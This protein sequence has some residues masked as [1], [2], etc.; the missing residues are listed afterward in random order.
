MQGDE[1]RTSESTQR[2][3]RTSRIRTQ[4]PANEG[5]EQ[6]KNR[7]DTRSGRAYGATHSPYHSSFE[8]GTSACWRRP[9]RHEGL[10]TLALRKLNR[11]PAGV[12]AALASLPLGERG[13]LAP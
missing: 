1:H 4:G 13:A 9:L 8:R 5:S 3:V 2:P 10:A 6:M 12:P 11:Q 7:V